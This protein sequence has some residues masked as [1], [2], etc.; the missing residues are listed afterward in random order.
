MPSYKGTTVVIKEINIIANSTN[1]SASGWENAASIVAHLNEYFSGYEV[2][3]TNRTFTLSVPARPLT[4]SN[5]FD[6][7]YYDQAWT[8]SGTYAI[9][10][11][12]SEKIL[13]NVTFTNG[14]ATVRWSDF[15][16]LQTTTP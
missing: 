13:R 10:Q 3:E 16:T 11:L 15:V 1:T 12:N 6:V 9:Y 8:G 7:S 4:V 14:C 5:S 2:N